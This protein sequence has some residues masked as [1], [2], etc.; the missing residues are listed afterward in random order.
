MNRRRQVMSTFNCWTFQSAIPVAINS[1][2][3]VSVQ[4][5]SGTFVPIFGGNVVDIGLEVR[6]VGTT[7]FT[8]TYSITALGR[9]GAFAEGIDRRRVVKGF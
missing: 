9:I 2:L 5:T 3:G 8:Q 4:D 1:T 6:D 7:M